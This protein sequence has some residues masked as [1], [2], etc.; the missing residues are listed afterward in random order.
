MVWEAP[1]QSKSSLK[2]QGLPW[3]VRTRA[4][5]SSNYHLVFKDTFALPSTELECEAVREEQRLKFS[6]ELKGWRCSHMHSANP[7]SDNSTVISSCSPM[8]HKRNLQPVST[9]LLYPLFLT[10]MVLW[11]KSVAGRTVQLIAFHW[12]RA[13]G[14]GKL[15]THGMHVVSVG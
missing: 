14:F 6:P 2:S 9:H 12:V 7:C 13:W 1:A 8:A 15:R 5:L 10:L 3:K 4:S 11:Q